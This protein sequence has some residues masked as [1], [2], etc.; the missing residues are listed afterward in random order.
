MFVSGQQT[1]PPAVARKSATV[2]ELFQMMESVNQI[3]A[4]YRATR[5][6]KP[7]MR[8]RPITAHD[9]PRAQAQPNL[10]KNRHEGNAKIVQSYDLRLGDTRYRQMI[11]KGDNSHYEVYCE[12]KQTPGMQKFKR[13]SA[14]CFREAEDRARSYDTILV[15][16]YELPNT[17]PASREASADRR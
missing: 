13:T 4:S 16:T 15:V 10:T 17:Y 1:P 7:Q 11:I 8:S 6:A 2:P 14:F 5:A 3:G 9:P 12:D